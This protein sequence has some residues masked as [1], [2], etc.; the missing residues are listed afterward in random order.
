MMTLDPATSRPATPLVKIKNPNCSDFANQ[1]KL[2]FVEKE[3]VFGQSGS[4]SKTNMA[5]LSLPDI[6]TN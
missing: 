4:V 6:H 5:I 2:G 3:I 1:A